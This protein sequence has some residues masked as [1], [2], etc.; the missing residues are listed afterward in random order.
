MKNVIYIPAWHNKADMRGIGPHQM[1]LGVNETD[2][3]KKW[4]EE[5]DTA[6]FEAAE[7][8]WDRVKDILDQKIGSGEIDLSNSRLYSEGCDRPL[9]EM[10][11]I[12]AVSSREGSRH[13]YMALNLIAR[14]VKYEMTESA[15]LLQQRS[16][17]Y[18]ILERAR[19]RAETPTK[20]VDEDR[21]KLLES[22]R[23][24]LVIRLDDKILEG[25]Q[26]TDKGLATCISQTLQEEETGIIIFGASHRFS[27]FLPED[28]LFVPLD[29]KFVIQT[30]GD[31]G[32][33]GLVSRGVEKR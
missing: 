5:H 30:N 11:P 22:Q 15:D 16:R 25:S 9:E 18:E 27:R 29:E 20:G 32:R 24:N 3:T 10:R 13:D 12:L 33:E 6:Y 23:W 2:E 7:R 17:A 4:A 28:V 14:G 8:Y 19:R 26:N 21:K 31:T 1:Q